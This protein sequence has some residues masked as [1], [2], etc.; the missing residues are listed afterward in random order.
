MSGARCLAHSFA[1]DGSAR[2]CR[3]PECKPNF[4]LCTLHSPYG[5]EPRLPPRLGSGGMI[6]EESTFFVPRCR[7][8]TS[9]ASVTTKPIYRMQCH[10]LTPQGRCGN[11][12]SLLPFC[13]AHTL[14]KLNVL[15]DLQSIVEG[16]FDLGM[17]AFNVCIGY[18]APVFVTG[19]EVVSATHLSAF[20]ETYRDRVGRTNGRTFYTVLCAEPLPESDR[21]KIYGSMTAPNTFSM[22]GGQMIDCTWW[23]SVITMPNMQAGRCN[24]H[25]V[26]HE[27]AARMPSVS[28]ETTGPIRQGAAVF[29]S[30][31]ESREG[32]DAYDFSMMPQ[33]ENEPRMPSTP[34]EGTLYDFRRTVD[35]LHPLPP[36]LPASSSG[37]A[38]MLKIEQTTVRD[39]DGMIHF[40]EKGQFGRIRSLPSVLDCQTWVQQLIDLLDRTGGFGARLLVDAVL[41]HRGPLLVEALRLWHAQQ[42]IKLRKEAPSRGSKRTCSEA[43]DAAELCGRD[44]GFLIVLL[45][46]VMPV[47]ELRPEQV[48]EVA[49]EHIAT[50]MCKL[51]DV[52]LRAWSEYDS[53]VAR[54]VVGLLLQIAPWRRPLID[55]A[56]S[57]FKAVDF[58]QM[59]VREG[60]C[61]N[62]PVALLCPDGACTVRT[63][64]K[65]WRTRL[66]E[67]YTYVAIRPQ[68]L[69]R[70]HRQVFDALREVLTTVYTTLVERGHLEIPVLRTVM[71]DMC[72][73]VE[74]RAAKKVALVL[75]SALT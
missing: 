73:E 71:N 22:P 54:A 20:R 18:R 13:P 61:I 12:C 34:A 58:D 11:W 65:Q 42:Q 62:L 16:Q 50:F 74:H 55:T 37:D 25:L 33:I 45:A 48:V 2:R 51:I 9:D 69:Q 14:F 75:E 70:T 41:E 49:S 47:K 6:L 30:Y 4:G 63:H 46:V 38:G 53:I 28:I 72:L 40:F 5:A 64:F 56:A 7:V 43:E 24:A 44:V 26:P 10:A 8:V 59:R 32:V 17:Y 27:V 31:S 29:V 1:K 52:D 15:I 35:G 23:Q 39:L 19:S 57:P 3:E 36:L 66:V 68:R 60:W 21:A 67:N